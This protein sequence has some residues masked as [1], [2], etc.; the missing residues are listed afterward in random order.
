MGEEKSVM[1]ESVKHKGNFNYAD[2]YNYCYNWLKNEG[3][4]LFEKE[5]TEKASSFGK[6]IVIKWEANR[7]IT[8]Y[9]M[10]TIEVKWHILGMNDTEVEENGKK[11]KTNKGEVKLEISAKL[12]KDYEETWDKDPFY[13][14][15]RGIY[16]RYIMRTTEDEYED[17]LIDKTEKFIEDVKAFLNLEGKK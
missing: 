1:K 3:Y 14:F 7:K 4:L 16:D 8:D 12:K 5:Y 9:Y 2:F 15:L 6:E 10:F 13:K 11:I 17:K